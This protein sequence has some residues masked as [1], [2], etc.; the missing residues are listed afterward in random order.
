[1]ILAPGLYG[2]RDLEPGHCLETGTRE[3][4]EA[5]IDDFA[6]VSGDRYEIHMSV[7][8]ARA[9]G[10]PGR[11]A[12]GLLVLSV[13]DG[14][15][16]SAPARFDALASLGWDWRF[17][18]PVLAGDRV[19]AS[20]TVADKRLTSRGDRGVVTIEAKAMNQHGS[21]VQE[22]RNRLIFDL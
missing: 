7:Q 12:H 6:Q 3:I 15:K 5:L 18:A 21:V 2:Y 9:R 20:F 8:A 4:S 10:F 19:S 1:V 11:V 14:L 16:N 17:S 22:G 13:I